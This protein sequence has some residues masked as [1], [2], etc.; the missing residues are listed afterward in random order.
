[1]SKKKSFDELYDWMTDRYYYGHYSTAVWVAK[2]DSSG[3]LGRILKKDLGWRLDNE[4]DDDDGYAPASQ[5]EK[6]LIVLDDWLK[7]RK[8]RQIRKR[9]KKR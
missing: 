1:M 9:R 5:E 7:E 3:R 6:A 2:K 4:V 8:G